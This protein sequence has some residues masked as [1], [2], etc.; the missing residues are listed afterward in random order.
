MIGF[1]YEVEKEN[2]YGCF[3]RRD[4]Y[5]R[6]ALQYSNIQNNALKKKT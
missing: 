3:K 4:G 6:E 2:G 5:S 1:R